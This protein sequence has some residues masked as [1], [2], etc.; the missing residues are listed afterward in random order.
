MYSK[1]RSLFGRVF[2]C[3]VLCISGLSLAQPAMAQD[4]SVE[5]TARADAWVEKG[6]AAYR[7]GQHGDAL[8]AFKRALDHDATQPRIFLMIATVHID[9]N[10]RDEALAA[11]AEA[12]NLAQ[13]MSPTQI[14][15]ATKLRAIITGRDRIDHAREIARRLAPEDAPDDLAPRTVTRDVRITHLTSVGGV[16]AGLGVIALGAGFVFL[17]QADKG[18]AK[19][20]TTP[21]DFSQDE[22]NRLARERVVQQRNSRIGL[23]SGSLLLATGVGLVIWDAASVVQVEEPLEPQ[24]P[25]ARRWDFNVSPRGAMLE[26]QTSF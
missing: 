9:A 7:N 21:H 26:F 5:Q 17:N 1:H 23:V 13:N 18:Y 16:S 25:T 15:Q 3:S 19:L 6:V 12:E 10:A 14:Q 11:L 8:V 24:D 2:L 20:A 4:V 22:Y